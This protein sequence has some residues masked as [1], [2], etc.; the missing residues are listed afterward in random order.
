MNKTTV[1]KKSRGKAK[2]FTLQRAWY[3]GDDDDTTEKSIRVKVNLTDG[4]A[5][6]VWFPVK[7]ISR[8]RDGRMVCPCWLVNDK[9]SEIHKRGYDSNVRIALEAD[10]KL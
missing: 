2:T 9:N 4:S 3:S 1:V 7:K 10:G 5:A 6:W 8:G